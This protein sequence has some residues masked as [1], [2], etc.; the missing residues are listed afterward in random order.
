M[1]N[2]NDLV[3]D[4]R[5]LTKSYR[6]MDRPAVS[7]LTLRLRRGEVFGFVGPN[8]AGKTTTIKMLLNL[9]VP[10]AGGGTILGFNIVGDS[11][12]IRRR[13][14]FMS[15][16]VRL[17]NAMRGGELLR[18]LLS[19]HG[20]ADE[21]LLEE[22]NNRFNVPLERK[23]KTYSS[24][25][26]QMLALTAALAHPSE[27]LLLD[28]PTKGLDPSKKAQFF[29]LVERYRDGGGTALISSHVLSEIEAVCTR[30]GF[31]RRGVLLGDEEIEAVRGHLDKVIIASFTEEIDEER[32]RRLP[33]VSSV[34]KHGVEF[35][36]Q[37]DGDAR[38]ALRALADL[39]LASLRYR[40]AS[41][42]DLYTEL[43]MPE[44]DGEVE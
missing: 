7:D 16:E 27:L 9:A 19:M 26:K 24:G 2:E 1:A 10:D 17:W 4:V 42:D 37:V 5:G 8:G 11:V 23:V 40:S 38:D 15:G 41:L 36:F 34:R 29:E 14:G 30:V 32:L 18:F 28:E 12:E 31:I 20:G 21:G 3:I 35:I 43:Y 6:G 44:R 13:V 33:C 39:P 25:Q 22:L